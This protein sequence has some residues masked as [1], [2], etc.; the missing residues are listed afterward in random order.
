MQHF[1]RWPIKSAQDV[2]LPAALSPPIEEPLD[3]LVCEQNGCSLITINVDTLRI[4]AK[5][6]HNTAWMGDT[7]TLESSRKVEGGRGRQ[8]GAFPAIVRE[9]P[10]RIR[11]GRTAAANQRSRGEGTRGGIPAGVHMDR[12]K[13]NESCR[14]N[15]SV[16]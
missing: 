5:K 15:S 8:R 10:P 9:C 16:L 13:D 12:V 1:H 7:S 11:V 14:C 4:H 6:H 3:G 2:A